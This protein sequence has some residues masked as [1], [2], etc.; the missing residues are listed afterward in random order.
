MSALKTGI[1]VVVGVALAGGGYWYGTQRTSAPGAGAGGA[2]NG[3][4]ASAA[5]DASKQGPGGGGAGKA[6]GGQTGPVRV[7]ASKVIPAQMPQI[8]TT[9]GSL[10]SDESV[11][12]RPEVAGRI[13]DIKFTEGQ[14]VS[15]GQ[16]LIQLDSAVNQAEVQQAR[17]NL[18][19]AK[20]KYERAVD[21]AG[22]NF[23]SG[24][25][26]DEAKSAYELAVAS[27]ALVE[28]RFSKT[29]IK[30]PFSGIIGLRVVSIGDYVKEGADLVN[31][32]AIDPIKVDF[33]VPETFLRDVKVGQ[34]LQITLDAIPGK[35][36]DG[37]VIAVNPLLDAAGRSV[38]VRAQ[39][40]NQD[41]TLRPGM[42]ARINLVTQTK[43]DAMTVP[44][45]ALVPQGTDNFV[46][47]IIDGKALRA[48]VETGQRREGKVEIV[49]GIEKDDV[50]VT[51]G[52]ARLRDGTPVTVG[53]GKPEGSPDKTAAEKSEKSGAAGAT[54]APPQ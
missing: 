20:S 5:G 38:V 24:Q 13:I 43:R 1:L 11:T 29:E 21:L 19:L 28:A 22:K 9:V 41:T 46:F 17:T 2:P 54:K 7:E 25:A 6:Q 23:I 34:T 15:K 39:V 50:I 14:R 51:A 16:T 26:R 4:Q 33:R 32:E 44:E 10:R 8:I 47:R 40:R 27:L 45:E 52:Q 42:F 36:Y 48:K 35:N 53:G 3:Q 37:K 30:A 12:L 18:D 31:L 49:T